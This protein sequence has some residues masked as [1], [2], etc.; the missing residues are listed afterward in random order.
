M[1]GPSDTMWLNRQFLPQRNPVLMAASAIVPHTAVQ[2]G[3]QPYIPP[4]SLQGEWDQARQN[5]QPMPETGP[6]LLQLSTQSTMQEAM[7]Q[8]GTAAQ[9]LASHALDP[10]SVLGLPSY[11]PTAA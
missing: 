5:E 11:V 3:T 4:Q 10:N 9:A 2:F 7:G 1:P 8:V 6:H